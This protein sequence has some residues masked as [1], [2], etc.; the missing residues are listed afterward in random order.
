MMNIYGLGHGINKYF[1]FLIWIRNVM[2]EICTA[3]IKLGLTVRLVM[4]TV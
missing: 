1:S 2:N 3:H 4:N